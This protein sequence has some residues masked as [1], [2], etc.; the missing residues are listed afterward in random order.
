[1]RIRKNKYLFNCKYISLVKKN[2]YDD[3]L[4]S[5]KDFDKINSDNLK[6]INEIKIENI[7]YFLKLKMFKN[8]NIT[9][10]QEYELKRCLF[11]MKNCGEVFNLTTI[12]QF[13]DNGIETHFVERLRILNNL[14][15]NQ[16]L[17][18]LIL[19]HGLKIGKYKFDNL[20]FKTNNPGKNHGGRLSPFS[21]KFIKY[22]DLTLKEKQ[23]NISKVQKKVKSSIKEHPENQ[24]TKL[25]YYKKRGL[26]DNEAENA[27]KKRQSTFSKEICI[28]KYVLI[29]GIEIFEK[30][31]SKW[32]ETLNNK[33]LEEKEEINTKKGTGVYNQIYTN[34]DLF[35]KYNGKLYFIKF[36]NEEII[37]YKIGITSKTIKER[38]RDIKK[39]NLNM[40]ILLEMDDNFYNCFLKEQMILNAFKSCRETIKY[41]FFETTEA[42]NRNILKDFI[43]YV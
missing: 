22:D 37:F 18:Y 23:I 10:S 7:D 29:K 35:K 26:S 30:R 43:K 25:E 41:K 40:E 8:K 36:Y 33:T 38:F 31:Q 24:N 13:I 42:F 32:Q 27:L 3:I 21:K 1:M 34:R 16:G 20:N 19:K 11:F 4:Y 5:R 12:C 39:S 6:Q 2:I 9:Q 14:R 15:N 17:F 28:E